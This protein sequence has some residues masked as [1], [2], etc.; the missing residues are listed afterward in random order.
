MQDRDTLPANLQS[1][2][3]THSLFMS[4]YRDHHRL[5]GN[6]INETG[7]YPIG[8][9]LVIQIVFHALNVSGI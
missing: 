2:H 8:M 1:D 4:G 3:S 7:M 9:E 6:I 5:M